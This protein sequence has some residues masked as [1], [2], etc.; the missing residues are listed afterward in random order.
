MSK[1]L[2]QRLSTSKNLE[3]VEAIQR[4][5]IVD[6]KPQIR[7]VLHKILEEFGSTVCE[8]EETSR[9]QSAIRA[10]DP[11]VVFVGFS[12]GA[13]EA[14]AT[15]KF[16]A[17]IQFKGKVVLFGQSEDSQIKTAQQIGKKI[18]LA[19]L[20]I[21]ATPIDDKSLLA[22]LLR[23]RDLDISIDV[24]EALN[25][26]WVELWYQ[27]KFN[28]Q[29]LQI[30]GFEALARIR[31]P[32]WGILSPASFLPAKGDPY[33]R[34]FSEFVITQAVE[35]WNKVF[36]EYDRLDI[37]INVPMDYLEEPQSVALLK[38]NVP[39]SPDFAGLIV[40]IDAS[41]LI[42]DLNAAKRIA[43]RLKRCRI[44]TS[45]DDVASE[46]PVLASLLDSPFAEIKVDRGLIA[47]CAH[48]P[49]KRSAC[50][51][52]VNFAHNFKVRTVAEGVEQ[53]SEFFAI[54][55]LGFD[56]V[57]GFLFAKP[58]SAP[59]CATNLLQSPPL[60]PML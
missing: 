34:V 57:Q 6:R 8:C 56:L 49:L 45:I 16:M 48:A 41:D 14:I 15:L 24:A 36:R 13:I 59:E 1:A 42:R 39:D 52:I 47:E 4:V 9:L 10:N 38:R 33:R 23:D 31:H 12:N 19:M 50:R 60:V 18:G 35:D 40:E 3:H 22:D 55:E 26:G 27:P 37:A 58:M 28:V 51:K 44:A 53:K 2:S 43:R 30:S 20:P 17:A 25:A 11:G 29:S 7:A 54:R 21:L 5:C 46:W 32:I